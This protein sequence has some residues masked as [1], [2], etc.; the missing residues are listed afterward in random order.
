MDSARRLP[1]SA[2]REA[3][4]QKDS[5][6]RQQDSR[7]SS[8][9]TTSSFPS[10]EMRTEGL[11]FWGRMG[12]VSFSFISSLVLRQER[13]VHLGRTLADSTHSTLRS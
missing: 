8:R 4:R 12:T 7:A 9:V 11:S 5:T 1:S 10:L 2:C 13:H 6:V 3:T